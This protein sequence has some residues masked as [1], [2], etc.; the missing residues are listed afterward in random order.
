MGFDNRTTDPIEG[1]KRT[2]AGST[3]QELQIDKP[4]EM[5]IVYRR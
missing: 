1:K 5:L 2:N 4:A 3:C